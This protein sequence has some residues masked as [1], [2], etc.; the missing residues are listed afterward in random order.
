MLTASKS[1]FNLHIPLLPVHPENGKDQPLAQRL[2]G[3]PGYL[4]LVEQEL[5]GSLGI[6]GLVTGFLVH[7]N[8][9]VVKIDTL[10]LNFGVAAQQ[11][12]TT[13]SEG[14]DLGPKQGNTG[15][16]FFQD[17]VI[18]ESLPVG[19]DI[20]TH[21]LDQAGGIPDLLISGKE[22]AVSGLAY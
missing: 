1:D 11:I 20:R 12:N 3:Q 9:G 21:D 17:H 18:P 10:F 6:M 13:G 4:N 19:D 22:A 7:L 14:L 8:G 5:P 2:L 15:L 16:D